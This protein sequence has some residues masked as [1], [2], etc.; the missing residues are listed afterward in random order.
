MGQRSLAAATT[1][2]KNF[3][4]WAAPAYDDPLRALIDSEPLLAGKA[5]VTVPYTTA[6]YCAVKTETP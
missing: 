5:E 1:G 4:R 6:A 3:V 2:C